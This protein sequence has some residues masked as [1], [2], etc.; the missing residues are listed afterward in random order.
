M[1]PY[2]SNPSIH[3][4]WSSDYTLKPGNLPIPNHIHGSSLLV[5]AQVAPAARP[6]SNLSNCFSTLIP[7]S[8]LI[9][10]PC[11]CS[12]QAR[13][14][15]VEPKQDVDIVKWGILED[16]IASSHAMKLVFLSD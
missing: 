16:R 4:F 5:L 2:P 10:S 12:K 7:V 11:D 8:L 6:F 14:Y 3:V 1:D 9:L 13:L 15:R